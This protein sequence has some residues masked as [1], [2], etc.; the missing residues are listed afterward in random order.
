MAGR[1]RLINAFELRDQLIHDYA[2]FVSSFVNIRDATIREYVESEF[3]SGTLWPQPLLQLNPS[4][5][6]GESIDEL[7]E[8]GT[9]HERCA[10]VFRQKTDIHD[11]GEEI[12]LYRHQAEAVKLAAAGESYVLTTGTGSGKSLAYI[13]PIVDRILRRGSSKG[14]QAVIVYPMNALANSQCLELEKFLKFGFPE[15]KAPVTFARYTGQEKEERR[16]EIQENPPDIILTNYVMLEL[17]LTR[18]D[19]AP[20]V[21]AARDLQFLVLDELH[22]YRGRQGADVAMLVRRAR[23]AFRAEN[24]QCIGTSATMA[25]GHGL[26]S[27]SVTVAQVSSRIFGIEVD[28][29]HVIGEAL[30]RLTEML[31]EDQSERSVLLKSAIETG[32]F[33][34]ESF[35]GLRASPLAAWI[36]DTVGIRWNPA[37]ERLE[38]QSP[39]SVSGEKGL[40][41]ELSDLTGCALGECEKA[42]QGVLL[43]GSEVKD[44]ETGEP[45]FAYRLHQFIS[46][47]DTVYASIDEDTS[48][49]RH[50]TLRGQKFVPGARDR[51]LLPLVFCRHCGQPYYSV[52]RDTV[53][54]ERRFYKPRELLDTAGE[55]EVDA[56]YLYVSSDYPWPD[57]IEAMAERLPEDWLQDDGKLRR[58]RRKHLPGNV[59]VGADGIE[60]EGGLRSTFVTAPFRFC[61]RCG[62]SYDFYQRSDFPKLS[63]VG[64]EGRSTATTILALSMIRNMELA[65]Y[66]STSRKLLSFTDNRQDASLQAGHFNDFVEVG[67]LRSAL[68][69]AVEAAGDEGIGHDELPA[70]VFEQLGFPL[71]DY[72][73]DPGIKGNARDQTDA[74]MREVITYRIYR[75]LRRGWRILAPNLEQTGLLKIGYPYVEDASGDEDEWAKTHAALAEASPETRAEIAR[76]LLD[77][78]RRQLALRVDYLTPR[79]QE[80][81]LQRSHQHLAAPWGFDENEQ[82]RN[83]SHSGVAYPRSRQRYDTEENV[84]VS[85]RGGF[86]RYLRR[87]TT[88]PEYESKLSL[89]ETGQIIRDLLEVL[90][91]Y[92]LVSKAGRDPDEDPGY[93]L[94]ASAIRWYPGDGTSGFRDPIRQPTESSEATPPNTFFIN[95]Y[96]DVAPA[97]RDIR[98]HE[99]TAQV[100]GDV[101]E[102]REELFRNGDLPILFCSPTMEL[103]IDIA[104]LNAVNL[105]NVPPTPANYAQR[106]G[107]AGRS[108]QAAIVFTYCSGGSPHDQ[109]YFRHPGQMVAGIVSPP[110][111][112][113]TNEDLLRAHVHA[114]W[115]A[116][117]GLKLGKTLAEV[118]DLST[119]P[120]AAKF[121]P[122]V[123]DALANA[124][125]KLLARER[126]ERVL[127][128]LGDDL[129]HADWY[130]EDWLD[131]VLDA[132]PVSFDQACNRWRDLYRS[133]HEQSR[134]QGEIVRD[135]SRSPQDKRRAQRLRQEAEKQIS[136]LTEAENIAQSDFYSYRYFA[137]EGFLPGYNFP[138]LPLSAFV[139]G[140][141]MRSGEE[142]Y[143]SRPRFLAITEF[144]PRAVIYHEGSQYVI[145]QV[146]LPAQAAED[147]DTI[148]AKVCENCGYL[149]PCKTGEGPERCELCDSELPAPWRRLFRLQN[150]VAKRRDRITCDEEERLR[151]GYDV[152][153]VV[154]FAERYGQPSY[155][156]GRAKLDGQVIAT[157]EYGQSADLWRVNLG[158]RRRGAT[159]QDGFDLDIERG[160]WSKREDEEDDNP[161]SDRIQRVVPYVQDSKNCLILRPAEPQETHVMASLQAALKTALQRAYDLEDREL[162]VEA[163][164]RRDRRHAILIYEAAE[165][166]L[167][168]LG[169]VL[170][171]PEEFSRIARLALEICHFDPETGEDRRR[172]EHATEDCEAACYDCLLSYSNQRDHDILDRKEIRDILLQFARSQIEASPLPLLRSEHL[173]RLLRVCG[174]DLERVWLNHL[175]AN[176]CNLPSHAQ[177]LFEACSTR[178]DFIYERQ[179]TVIY[180]DGPPHDYPERSERDKQQTECMEDL[181]WTVIR[182]THQDDWDEI[183]SR[184]KGTFGGHT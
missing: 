166:G 89:E 58:D 124:S 17:I 131:S 135:A 114:L 110:P 33:S 74:A 121:Q 94:E 42:I 129:A 100:P 31:P 52:W 144:G 63:P 172:A 151:M 167:G 49:D 51:I 156:T 143:L 175:E 140:R 30:R 105:R 146:M 10:S 93:Q 120:P 148:E 6:R 173:E 4:F 106:S 125:A 73:F 62:V 171:H 104:E 159:S 22:T 35:G 133:A 81:M 161:M 137:S 60:K 44:P 164:P 182:F 82:L 118:L 46:R 59:S 157:I 40:A 9:L 32:K 142:E 72:A 149:H 141:V 66:D 24:L 23:E 3:A 102:K 64:T 28:D 18:P 112:D 90:R 155:R 116:E 107:R 41:K 8:V 80:G 61:L 88:F 5:E 181:G 154:R 14:V 77:Y 38:R 136:L 45:A 99:H 19:D 126:A 169:R 134:K 29:R 165:G 183:L 92:G 56:G 71:R 162:S 68:Q 184:Y 145:N 158:W 70:R 103:G 170:G 95:Y 27:S 85:P 11:R 96:R 65:A 12:R 53:D 117:T 123:D 25:S 55:G 78:L 122:H 76:V 67:L 180:V 176:D 84:Y 43:A 97:T 26:G 16:I 13:I 111:I 147:I 36:E 101:R 34:P 98:A 178:P 1:R 138:R 128:T 75:D 109:Y 139:P 127:S 174:S 150:V 21:R 7:I 119:S 179:R 130:R 177:K 15:G 163:L 132:I 79:Y 37:T 47:G 54:P 152:H 108:G 91:T 20:L 50:L 69:R 86:G 87:T 2:S 160:Y 168:A 113:L 153:T 48:P 83:L 39:R 57:D 115:L